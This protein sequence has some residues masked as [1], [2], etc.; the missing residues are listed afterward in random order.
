M[1]THPHQDEVAQWDAHVCSNAHTLGFPHLP[2]G[3]SWKVT[4]VFSSSPQMSVFLLRSILKSFPLLIFPFCQ[5][6]DT[7]KCK[8]IIIL[9]TSFTETYVTPVALIIKHFSNISL[10]L[11]HCL[12]EEEI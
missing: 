8:I 3:S 11:H 9:K 5:V 12:R 4:E 1:T 10:D 6:L 2:P 7:F